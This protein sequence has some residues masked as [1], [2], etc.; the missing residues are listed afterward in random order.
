[1]SE[2]FLCC[3]RFLL[4]TLNK[5]IYNLIEIVKLSLVL[6]VLKLETHLTYKLAVL[7][8][9]SLNLKLS[10]S[11]WH[12]LKGDFFK[13]WLGLQF[14]AVISLKLNVH[15]E[16]FQRLDPLTIFLGKVWAVRKWSE[17]I[18]YHLIEIIKDVL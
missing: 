11:Q 8:S 18:L 4:V 12:L 5:F 10:N 6:D 2:L 3:F 16:Q 13:L 15:A 9:L 7:D 17:S 14:L 1:M